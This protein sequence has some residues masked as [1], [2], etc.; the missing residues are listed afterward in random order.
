MESEALQRRGRRRWVCLGRPP[1]CPLQT[2]SRL[3]GARHSSPP[4]TTLPHK[5]RPRGN[6]SQTTCLSAQRNAGMVASRARACM[7]ARTPSL[8]VLQEGCGCLS[9]PLPSL[10]PPPPQPPDDLPPPPP[11]SLLL[12]LP[13][14]HCR[15]P[16][17]VWGGVSEAT[18]PSG[19]SVPAFA[20]PSCLDAWGRMLPGGV[21]PAGPPSLG[22]RPPATM[23]APSRAPPPLAM[24]TTWAAWGRME[25]G[26]RRSWGGC[27]RCSE[28]KVERS[29]APLAAA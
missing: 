27:W 11:P 18:G 17:G 7:L 1:A 23:D 24:V 22:S 5:R 12:L 16:E 9:S 13:S 21:H 14:H 2:A 19:P 10:P 15:A 20:R 28:T 25:G 26:G 4:I 8:R 29:A 6:T 3:P